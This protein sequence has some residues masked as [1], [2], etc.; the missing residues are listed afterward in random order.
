MASY[1]D[2]EYTSASSKMDQMK[3]ELEEYAKTLMRDLPQREKPS[4]PSTA[5]ANA[6]RER[7]SAPAP[8]IPLAAQQP[9][10]DF[11][12]RRFAKPFCKFLSNNPTVF[13]ASAALAAQ[14]E[15]A[16]F[17]RLSE[18][19]VWK[20]EKGGK[21]FVER[22]GSSLIAFGVGDAYEPGNGV[23]MIAGHIDALTARL[24]P[25]PTKTNSQGFVQLG[26]AAYSGG[27]NNTWWDRDLAVAGRVMVKGEDGKIV[28]KLVNLAEP[29]MCIALVERY[30]R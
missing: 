11:K 8:A 9:Y 12:P 19:D 24:K 2:N 26:V 3:R 20:L 25:I 14:C 27:M 28:Q 4:T 30:H 22:N 13:H 21:Y 6:N 29:S 17:T 15:E 1:S 18:R 5:N 23:A 16:G 10:S 7:D